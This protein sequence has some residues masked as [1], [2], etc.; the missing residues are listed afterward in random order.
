MLRKEEFL[1][2]VDGMNQD[3]LRETVTCYSFSKTYFDQYLLPA[4]DV[5]RDLRISSRRIDDPQALASLAFVKFVSDYRE[6][7]SDETKNDDANKAGNEENELLSDS[8]IL[9]RLLLSDVPTDARSVSQVALHAI[10]NMQYVTTDFVFMQTWRE[11][12]PYVLVRSG[13][14]FMVGRLVLSAPQSLDT[15]VDAKQSIRGLGIQLEA[16]TSSEK[17]KAEFSR[18]LAQSPAQVEPVEPDVTRITGVVL[19]G[20]G[21]TQSV[22]SLA[23]A[24]L[25]EEDKNTSRTWP[26]ISSE[27]LDIKRLLIDETAV[28]RALTNGTQGETDRPIPWRC[29]HFVTDLENVDNSALAIRCQLDPGV[30]KLTLDCDQGSIE[31][32]L[33]KQSLEAI[34]FVG[35][36][37]ASSV[38]AKAVAAAVDAQLAQGLKV[39]AEVSSESRDAQRQLLPIGQLPDILARKVRLEIGNTS[40]AVIK[41]LVNVLEVPVLD[42]E[43]IELFDSGHFAIPTLNPAATPQGVVR[44][45]N[46]LWY[47]RKDSTAASRMRA[48][49]IRLVKD[50]KIDA[51]TF[52]R[53]IDAFEHKAVQPASDFG[54]SN[55]NR[56]AVAKAVLFHAALSRLESEG[57]AEVV[58]RRSNSQEREQ[59]AKPLMSFYQSKDEPRVRSYLQQ[60]LVAE[61]HRQ[62]KRIDKAFVLDVVNDAEIVEM[63]VEAIKAPIEQARQRGEIPEPDTEVFCEQAMSHQE[64]LSELLR[65]TVV[66]SDGLFILEIANGAIDGL[67]RGCLI[68]W[69]V[70]PGNDTIRFAKIIWGPDNNEYAFVYPGKKYSMMDET[71][72]LNFQLLINDVFPKPGALRYR[73]IA[74]DSNIKKSQPWVTKSAASVAGSYEATWSMDGASVKMS[75]SPSGV[76]FRDGNAR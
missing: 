58:V 32:A 11:Q 26:T 37:E 13:K 43:A 9:H 49:S 55:D 64:T 48:D 52:G 76:L 6:V 25:F 54:V 19:V 44:S 74:P 56:E 18:V 28:T 8:E 61:S 42:A 51:S 23:L 67:D 20:T 65:N 22:D 75:V 40:P 4:M 71:L 7:P 62:R 29:F 47:C 12:S 21:L 17:S 34:K 33:P 30:S 60:L 10:E 53:L 36:S 73:I 59:S 72:G 16:A 38:A 27:D 39:A 35:E 2:I 41:E 50:M 5:L 63:L 70:Q 66:T 69:R 24:E 3:G 14:Q 15:T 31:C 57:V 68:M 45:G 1:R 46:V